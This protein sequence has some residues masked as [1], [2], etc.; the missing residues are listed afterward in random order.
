MKKSGIFLLNAARRA[1]LFAACAALC[2]I[3]PAKGAALELVVAGG[4][5]NVGFTPEGEF[6]HSVF[7]NMMIEVSGELRD[8]VSGRVAIEQDSVF[9]RKLSADFSYDAGFIKIAAGPVLGFFNGTDGNSWSAKNPIQPGARLDISLF[10]LD[11]ILIEAS[12]EFCFLLPGESSAQ[13]YPS[14]GK[15]VLGVVFPIINCSLQV[16]YRGAVLSGSTGY[17]QTR[18]DYGLYTRVFS[19]NSPF[20]MSVNFI[21]RTFDYENSTLAQ[22]NKSIVLGG[23]VE[24]RIKRFEIFVNGEGTVFT[25]EN[26]TGDTSATFNVDAGVKVKI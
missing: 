7:P 10:F 9:G 2:L 1:P 13:F 17:T 20:R 8:V 22:S 23:G 12:S 24:F 26:T 14:Q 3:A 5:G 25:I 18:T 15:L 6:P 21:Y 16:N 4:A 19:K 11:R